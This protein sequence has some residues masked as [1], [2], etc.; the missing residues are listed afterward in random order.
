MASGMV[1]CLSGT[2]EF[3]PLDARWPMPASESDAYEA[4]PSGDLEHSAV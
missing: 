2:M 4:L 3:V 1:V